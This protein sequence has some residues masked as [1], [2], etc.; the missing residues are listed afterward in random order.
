VEAMSEDELQ[1]YHT[2][3]MELVERVNEEELCLTQN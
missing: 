3:F 1:L 2:A